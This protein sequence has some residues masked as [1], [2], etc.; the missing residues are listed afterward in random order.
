MVERIMLLKLND[1][2]KR[3]QLAAQSMTALSNI[4]ELE[5]L[6]VGVPADAA[7]EK[8]WDLSI[9]IGVANLSLLNTVLE[10]MRF[11]AFFEGTLAAQAAVVKAWN[12]D[13]L[14]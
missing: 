9:V 13:R 4:P 1:P 14:G 11:T 7:S 2:E 6:S 3:D 12:F 10:G 5:E 8:S